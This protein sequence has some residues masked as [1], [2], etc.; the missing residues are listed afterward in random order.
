MQNR[1]VVI[2]DITNKCNLK[3]KHCYAAEKYDKQTDALS[4]EEAKHAVDKIAHAGF[5]QI[6]F[7][8][9]EPLCFEKLVDLTGYIISKGMK[10]SLTTNGVLLN[11][12]GVDLVKV[13]VFSIFVSLDGTSKEVNDSIRG[14][15]TFEKVTRNFSELARYIKD[16]SSK[17][18]LGINFTVTT[19]NVDEL[20]NT[21]KF[22][23]Q[24]GAKALFIS[25]LT[26]EGR[27]KDNWSSLSPTVDKTLT[28]LE[29]LLK[30]D[31]EFPSMTVLVESRP[32]FIEYLTKKY[33]IHTKI[34]SPKAKCGGGS[35][36]IAILADGTV[37]PCGVCGSQLGYSKDNKFQRENL[38]IVKQSLEEILSSN[39]F[40][41]FRE[42]VENPKIYNISECKTCHNQP[43]CSPC[44]LVVDEDGKTVSMEECQWVKAKL[45]E[46]EAK[47]LQ[48]VPLKKEHHS[49]EDGKN[50]KIIMNKNQFLLEG[51][52]GRIWELIDGV[53][54]TQTI[55]DVFCHQFTDSDNPVIRDDVMDFLFKL[56]NLGIITLKGM[57]DGDDI[58]EKKLALKNQFLLR[59]EQFGGLLFDRANT[60]IDCFS[61]TVSFFPIFLDHMTCEIMELCNGEVTAKEIVGTICSHHQEI[62]AK[63]CMDFLRSYINMGYVEVVL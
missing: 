59:K 33:G 40:T 56:R 16:S 9:G 15:G 39:F 47:V 8:G 5:Q 50:L 27:A 48:S 28:L 30:N 3:C 60:K 4:F 42:Y 61:D 13:G 17:T 25:F 49:E 44:P 55:I 24:L 63:R 26:H 11:E 34:S 32:L 36:N 23:N 18:V 29:N 1:E 22:A 6:Q 41:T 19:M 12:Y 37:L 14:E 46:L 58:R 52:G 10:V 53:A 31:T 38:N 2:W 51:T 7:V 62:P 43:F 21:M 57:E 20:P 45:K 35:R 54:S